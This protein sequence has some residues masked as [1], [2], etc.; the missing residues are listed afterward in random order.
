MSP[1]APDTLI[2]ALNWRYATKVFDPSR[3]ISEA[4]LKTLMQSLVL[5]P[6]SFGLQP[7]RFLVVTDP[8]VRA[9]LREAS[10]GQSQVT[11]CSHLVVFLARQQMTEAD[12]DHYI[13]RIAQVRGDRPEN[14][15]AYRGMMVGTLVTG[16]KAATV[17]E[18]AARQAYIALGQFMASAALLGLDSCPM[19][20]LDPKKYDEILGLESTPFRTVV[21]CPVG[22]RAEA[23]KYATLAK[24]R[25]PI[26][27]LVELR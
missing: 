9:R 27:E 14:L 12:V 2:S 21:A 8:Q 10:W 26:E 17:S 16:P 11:D 20:G 1:C 15:A 4:D 6:S 5:T 18:W 23:D 24:V 22:Y 13:E 3:K 19:E 7:Y 25:F